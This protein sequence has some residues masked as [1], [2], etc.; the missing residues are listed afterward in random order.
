LADVAC[1]TSALQYLHQISALEILPELADRV[2]VPPAVVAEL[3]A[4]RAIGI[5]LPDVRTIEWILIES[6][7][8]A[9]VDTLKSD[10]LGAGEA[11]VLAL[12]VGHPAVIAV[13]D[14]RFARRLAQQLGIKHTG[15]LGLLVDAKRRGLIAEIRPM[16]TQLQAL[17]FRIHPRTHRLI[18]EL[19]NESG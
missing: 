4:G 12:C 17:G 2:L 8:S 9:A 3:D 19:A 13:I 11:Q 10:E 16:L 6:P 14:D 15:T 1:D 7:A 18:L 5:A